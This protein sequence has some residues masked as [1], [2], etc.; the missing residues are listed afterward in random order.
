MW[1]GQISAG[2]ESRYRVWVIDTGPG[3]PREKNS[4]D[5]FSQ[6]CL[7]SAQLGPGPARWAPTETLVSHT[8]NIISIHL[9]NGLLYSIRHDFHLSVI[10]VSI[11]AFES[12]CPGIEKKLQEDLMIWGDETLSIIYGKV[13]TVEYSLFV[14]V[15]YLR[16]CVSKD[17]HFHFFHIVGTQYSVYLINGKYLYSPT[18]SL[19]ENKT[20]DKR[21]STPRLKAHLWG[22]HGGITASV[23]RF[24]G[25]KGTQ[26]NNDN[27]NG[28]PITIL[29]FC[30]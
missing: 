11:I 21:H 19:K 2:F 18:G 6:K 22:N 17:Y 5:Y 24:F 27:F 26:Q 9:L 1:F 29:Q 4:A 13:L 8:Q 30:V 20:S 15:Y 25:T 7:F 3:G 10:C 28:P 23:T 12:Y 16:L 14:R